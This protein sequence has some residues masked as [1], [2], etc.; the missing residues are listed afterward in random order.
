MIDIRSESLLSLA[1]AGRHLAAIQGGRPPRPSTFYR[2][3]TRGLR[4]HRLEV[5]RC[6]GR[7]ATSVEALQRFFDAL[8][9]A[10]PAPPIHP[11]AATP[12]ATL[13]EL[14]RLGI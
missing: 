4:G 10:A 1:A 3:A 7:V 8:T 11:P 6:G 14:D 9:A 2:W 13:S 12:D 5:I